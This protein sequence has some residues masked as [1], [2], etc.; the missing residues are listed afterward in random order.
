MNQLSAICVIP[1]KKV[2]TTKHKQ[3]TAQEG[4]PI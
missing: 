1:N 3:Q 2:I 4:N